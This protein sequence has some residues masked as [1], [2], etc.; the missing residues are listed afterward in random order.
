MGKILSCQDPM[1]YIENEK[2]KKH[3]IIIK[4]EDHYLGSLRY[5]IKNDPL[6][7]EEVYNKICSFNQKHIMEHFRDLIKLEKEILIADCSTLDFIKMDFI[8]YHLLSKQF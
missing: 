5:T 3:S 6:M 2:E 8:F 4:R 1:Q 7:N